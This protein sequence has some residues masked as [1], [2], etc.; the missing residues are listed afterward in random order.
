VS[1]DPYQLLD[2][3]PARSAPQGL[4]GRF[5]WFPGGHLVQLGRERTLARFATLARNHPQGC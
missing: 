3:P 5:E 2:A 1:A 4:V